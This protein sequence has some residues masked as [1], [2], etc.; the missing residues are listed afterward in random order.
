LPFCHGCIVAPLPAQP[1]RW[2]CTQTPPNELRTIGDHIKARR[3][4]LRSFQTDVAK[5]IGVHAASVQNWERNIGTPL[6]GQIPAVI[7][8]LGYVPFEHD[9]SLSGRI[10]WLRTCAGWIQDELAAAT[11]C[12]VSSIARLESGKYDNV[13]VELRRK[14]ERAL[15]KRHDLL[16]ISG[17]LEKGRCNA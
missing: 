2:I 7:R 8:F 6:P 4:E 13:M 14:V 12:G 10:R 17:Y 15:S 9:G 16:G 1:A 3:I 11:R 5:Q